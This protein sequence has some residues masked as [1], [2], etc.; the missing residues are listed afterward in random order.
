[1]F[2]AIKLNGY[3]QSNRSTHCIAVIVVPLCR[4][5]NIVRRRNTI[6][7]NYRES[8]NMLITMQ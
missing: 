2:L 5:N 8:V 1:M 3:E 4:L 7:T 6:E